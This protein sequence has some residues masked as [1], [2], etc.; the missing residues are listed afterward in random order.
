MSFSDGRLIP[1]V[2]VRRRGIEPRVS[3]MGCAAA[4]VRALH[5]FFDVIAPSCVELLDGLAHEAFGQ[6]KLDSTTPHKT[7]IFTKRCDVEFIRGKD[8]DGGLRK[9]RHV[10]FLVASVG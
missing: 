4:L 10:R 9:L 6:E 5:A 2:G 7:D 8:R 1:V 3:L